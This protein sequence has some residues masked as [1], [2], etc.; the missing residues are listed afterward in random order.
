MQDP[1]YWCA[2]LGLRT[3]SAR[4]EV[5]A[6]APKELPENVAAALAYVTFVPAIVFLML[7]PYSEKP[8]VR[9]HAWQ[10]VFLAVAAFVLSFLLTLITI[11]GLLFGAFSVLLLNVI[12]WLA[13][14]AIWAVCVV[15]ALKGRRFK[16]PV[17][18]ILAERQARFY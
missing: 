16:L 12:V 17:L 11:F 6:S 1:C 13:W 5:M 2:A 3:F 14:L 4:R 15:N 10:S 7:P 9:F 8:F 18:G